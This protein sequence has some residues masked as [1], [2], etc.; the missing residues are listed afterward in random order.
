MEN[1]EVKSGL[2]LEDFGELKIE[3]M[4]RLY[5]SPF[6]VL[7]GPSGITTIRIDF[8]TRHL[9]KDQA[10]AL[11]VAH[12]IKALP[13]LIAA[14]EN[15]TFDL[16]FDLGTDPNEARGFY[17]TAPTALAL[18]QSGFP[19]PT[20]AFG[21]TW[22]DPEGKRHMF[23]T[24]SGPR[25]NNL[26]GASYYLFAPEYSERQIRVTADELMAGW[27]Y[28]P[29]ADEILAEIVGDRTQA[30][31]NAYISLNPPNV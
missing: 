10:E 28:A 22:Y 24:F 12:A 11:R 25:Y 29:T 17:V 20:P 5:E 18:K 13:A 4:S 9:I 1:K 16:T 31:A 7:R 6:F 27:C 8:G 21:Q 3:R 30:L 19:Q 23:L 26:H 14:L 15:L 2:T